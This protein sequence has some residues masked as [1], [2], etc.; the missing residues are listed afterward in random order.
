MYYLRANCIDQGYCFI[1][2]SILIK[3]NLIVMHDFT[4]EHQFKQK[5][6]LSLAPLDKLLIV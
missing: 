5:H 1:I 3:C 2:Q 4:Q 6:C